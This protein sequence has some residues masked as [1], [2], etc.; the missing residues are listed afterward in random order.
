MGVIPPLLYAHFSGP[1]PRAT[2]APGDAAL[3]C[4]QSTCH[5]GLQAGGPINSFSGSVKATF[6]SGTT[7]TP[8]G[9][10]ITITVTVTDPQNTHYGFQMTARLASDL[11][12]G[13]AGDFNSTSSNVIVICDDGRGKGANGCPSGAPVEFIEHSFQNFLSVTTTPYTFT[14][15]P[16]ATD[17]GDVH[18][19]VAGNAVNL[20]DKA[21]A[22]DHV[23][24]ADYVLTPAAAGGGGAPTISQNGVIT[25]AAFGAF[26]TIAP[27]SWIEIYGSNLAGSQRTWAAADF[28][29]SKAPTSLDGV[30]VTINGQDA[31]VDYIS[32]GQVNAQV[33][34]NVGTGPMQLT[35]TNSSGT[36]S[37]YSI[38]VNPTQ[39]GLLAPPSFKIENNQYVTALF[40]DGTYVLPTGAIS[41]VTS[42]PAKPGETI[43]LYGVGFG[44]V[45]PDIPAGQIVSQSN[46]LTSS[47][48]VLFGGTP[49]TLPY[50][51]LAPNFVGLYQINAVVPSIANSDRVPL[52]F[53]LGGVAGTQTL[54]T[55]VHN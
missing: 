24:T 32:A 40:S 19:Y 23:Y 3:S 25:A 10:P 38:T 41:G 50:F 44:T 11:A 42:R 12:N 46:R 33:P 36:S 39:P 49:A 34:S 21:D 53:T 37:P 43:V 47:L 16:P 35:V 26:S 20:N 9:D 18:F 7:Y 28:N 29:G 17:V 22:G 51:G 27:G 13:Q 54:V 6:S 31:F 8:G 52:T 30:K 48:Q 14:W 1:D 5:T 45:D 2:G 15:T 55:S 4:A